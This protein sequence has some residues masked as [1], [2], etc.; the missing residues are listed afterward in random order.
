MSSLPIL[1]KKKMMSS[2]PIA[3][4]YRSGVLGKG[5]TMKEFL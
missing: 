2:L 4:A 5:E 1:I 3:E